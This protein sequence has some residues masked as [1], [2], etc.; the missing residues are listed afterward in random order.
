MFVRGIVEDALAGKAERTRRVAAR[1]A[2]CLGRT[3][4]RQREHQQ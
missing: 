3:V 1:R 2:N 4:Y